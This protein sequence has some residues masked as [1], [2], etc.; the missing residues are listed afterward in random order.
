MNRLRDGNEAE[1]EDGQRGDEDEKLLAAVLARTDGEQTHDTLKDARI[2]WNAI[3]HDMASRS[4][5]DYL[6]RWPRVLIRWKKGEINP[7]NAKGKAVATGN[8]TEIGGNDRYVALCRR[9]FTAALAGVAQPESER[10]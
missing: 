1:R 3:A 7:S 6:R 5:L 2:S 8:Q 9:H 4:E 10:A